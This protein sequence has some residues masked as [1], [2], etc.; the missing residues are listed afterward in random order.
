MRERVYKKL[1]TIE[2]E[3]AKAANE[4]NNNNSTW[5]SDLD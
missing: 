2:A 4:N 5:I 3:K 1:E